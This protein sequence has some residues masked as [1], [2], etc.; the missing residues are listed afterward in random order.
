MQQRFDVKN[1][2]F[3]GTFCMAEKKPAG[4]FRVD[5]GWFAG[6]FPKPAFSTLRAL[7]GQN[8]DVV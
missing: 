2:M 1:G 5:R 6:Y 7:S 4:G 3:A 8:R